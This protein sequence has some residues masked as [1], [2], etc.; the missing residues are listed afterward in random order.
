MKTIYVGDNNQVM[1]ICPKCGFEKIV[2]AINYRNTKDKVKGECKC[3]D[4]FQFTIEYRKH[5]R[6]DV[7]L[8]GEYNVQ[9]NGQKEEII[10]RDLSLTGLRFESLRPYQILK[11]DTFEVKFKLDNSSK[12]EIHKLVKVIWV[13][14][15]IVGTQFSKKKLYEID[16]GFYLKK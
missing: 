10:I 13:K 1:I 3:K 15:R 2:D 4:S 6:K 16:L 7:S 11:D 5:Y 12:K 8:P 9:R 14:D